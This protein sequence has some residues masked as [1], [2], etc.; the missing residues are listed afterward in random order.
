M[1]PYDRADDGK[2]NFCGIVSDFYNK[3]LAAYFASWVG[4]MQKDKRNDSYL[5]VNHKF[6]GQNGSSIFYSN[7]VNPWCHSLHLTV[8]TV[9]GY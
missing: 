8:A 9:E 1:H 2:S 4:K 6:F 3:I 5:F 7:N